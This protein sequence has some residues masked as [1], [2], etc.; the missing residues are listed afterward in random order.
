[1]EVTENWLTPLLKYMD[2]HQDVA[3]CQ[4]KLLSIFDKNSFEYAGASGGYIDKL[5]YPYCRGRVFETVEKDNGQYNDVAEISWATGA[6]LMIRSKDYW[7]VGALDG[8][9]FAHNEEID[10]CWRLRLYGHKIVC[11][12]ESKVYH[13]GG[14]T[15]P[16]S[17][18][19]KTYLNFRN[20]LTMLYKNLPEKELKYVM[21][22]RWILDYTA[23]LET[24]IVSKNVGDFKAIYKARKA[25]KKW[26]NDFKHDRE[27]IQKNRVDNGKND[28][29][30]IS[31]LWQYYVHNRK[32]F[33]DI[34]NHA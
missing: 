22:W 33:N 28:R 12:P 1:M 10:L 14:G 16:K 23:A 27:V 11:I 2:Q 6:C 34:I 26:R 7:N 3:A 21:R 13:V 5:G 8:R 19:M 32:T 30:N 15:L 31:L 18:P 20:N 9:F 25:F 4:P 24:L 29:M 17:N